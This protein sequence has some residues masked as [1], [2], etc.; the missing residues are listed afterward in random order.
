MSKYKLHRVLK[1]YQLLRNKQFVNFADAKKILIFIQGESLQELNK[2]SFNIKEKITD[3]KI[4]ILGFIKKLS[5]KENLDTIQFEKLI[6]K[7]D[8]NFWNN[9]KKK[10]I[11]WCFSQNS[12]ILINLDLTSSNVL[13]ILTA[14]SSSKIKCGC[15]SKY[16]NIFDLIINIT[17]EK[18]KDILLEQILFYLNT[19]QV[20][21]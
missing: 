2:T 18:E 12:D 8:L 21:N 4:V 9:P 19:I 17:S 10:D 5:K 3:K 13:N 15:K 1:K 20:K 6:T 14:A 7:K 11:E 16:Y